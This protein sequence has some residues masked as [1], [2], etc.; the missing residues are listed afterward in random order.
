MQEDRKYPETF[1]LDFFNNVFG[2]QFNPQWGD[3]LYRTL[4]KERA[5][6]GGFPTYLFSF[7]EK[8]GKLL[9]PYRAKGTLRS[10]DATRYED[11]DLLPRTDEIVGYKPRYTLKNFYNMFTV[12]CNPQFALALCEVIHE[13]Y[14]DLDEDFY[15]ESLQ[16]FVNQVD[17]KIESKERALSQISQEN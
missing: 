1:D 8:L 4:I 15:P 5:R 7:T 3:V 13:Y 16:S 12:Q 11:E 17:I 10:F 9:L 6:Q 2:L 14:R